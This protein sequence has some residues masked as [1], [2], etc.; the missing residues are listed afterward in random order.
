MGPRGVGD[1]QASLGRK[2]MMASEALWGSLAPLA[3]RWVPDLGE[4][5]PLASPTLCPNLCVCFL[6]AAGAS[7]R[8]RGGWR[9]GLHG[10]G[11]QEKVTGWGW[12]IWGVM[13]VMSK[14]TKG[15]AC[16]VFVFLEG[17]Q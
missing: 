1:P 6:G 14:V 7:W 4:G 13:G 9:C 8:E 16:A 15:G 17:C 11:S 10:M 5:T 12:P 2:E 3:Y